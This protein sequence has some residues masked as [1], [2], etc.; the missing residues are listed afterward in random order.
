MQ[1]GLMRPLD[2]AMQI[3]K[4]NPMIISLSEGTEPRVVEA[5]VQAVNLGIAKIILIGNED[6]IKQQLAKFPCSRPDHINLHD[7]I[8]SPLKEEFPNIISKTETHETSQ[9]LKS[10]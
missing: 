10:P 4:S 9:K 1:P 8:K 5:A 7:P 6:K 2:K 3:A